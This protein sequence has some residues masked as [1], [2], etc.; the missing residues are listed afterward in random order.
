M[1]VAASKIEPDH[2]KP[3]PRLLDEIEKPAGAAGDVEQSQSALIA[4]GEDLMQR[5]QR[6]AAHRIGTALE[7]HLDLRVVAIGRI[8]REP[9]A[10]LI[11]EVL[12]VV[13]RALARGRFGHHLAIALA[14]AP[15]M[16]LRQVR[17][18]Q[19]RAAQPR[20]QR[21]V[22]VSGERIDPRLDIG[23][24]PRQQACQ[25]GINPPLVR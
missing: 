5:R 3:R 4:P 10:G 24:V 19:P 20:E 9:A 25:V 16:D 7:Q 21:A 11:V 17:E 8:L 2:G 6:L 23:E 14:L 15:A 1:H 22:M 18:E 12:Q 13:V